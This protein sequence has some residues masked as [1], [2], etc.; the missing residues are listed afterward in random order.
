MRKPA[1]A[2]D[3]PARP[4]PTPLIS[5]LD[6]V[7]AAPVVVRGDA[8]DGAIADPRTAAFRAWCRGLPWTGGPPPH[9]LASP[10]ALEPWLDFL[11]M[12]EPVG[13]GADFRYLLYG[14]AI[15]KY[16]GFDMTGR[17][18]SQFASK[19]G[20]FFLDC[21]RE[22]A[23]NGTPLLTHNVAEH[24]LGLLRW[25]RLLCPFAA[26]DGTIR[27]VTTNHPLPIRLPPVAPAR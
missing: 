4:V 19:T 2:P 6:L 11:M 10:E 20:A 9:A 22:C 16:S 17:H 27:I 24:A 12:L 14:S 26:D 18:V 5:A 8:I 15:A 23:A 1:D 3:T 21:Y 7:P 25:E 13:G